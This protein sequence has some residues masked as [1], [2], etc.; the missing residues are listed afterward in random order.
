MLQAM[1]MD[2]NAAKDGDLGNHLIAN[3]N[4]I[5]VGDGQFCTANYNAYDRCHFPAHT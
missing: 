1:V 5:D 4:N 2:I 3:D